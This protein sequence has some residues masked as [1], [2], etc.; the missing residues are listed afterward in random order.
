M[1]WWI[2]VAF[3]GGVIFWMLMLR[4]ARAAAFGGSKVSSNARRKWLAKMDYEALLRTRTQIEAEIAT[5]QP[6]GTNVK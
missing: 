3:V 6:G 4:F 5:R 2:A 1:N